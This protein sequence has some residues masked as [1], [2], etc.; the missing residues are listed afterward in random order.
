[1]TEA[2]SKALKIYGYDKSEWKQ[3][4][5]ETIKPEQLSVEFGGNRVR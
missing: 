5:L 3:M 2:S 4:L 1:M